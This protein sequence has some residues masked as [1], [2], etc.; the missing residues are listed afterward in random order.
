M[1]SMAPE[2]WVVLFQLQ[3]LRLE[4]LVARGGISRRGLALFTRLRTFDGH[5]FPGHSRLFLFFLFLF[6]LLLFTFSLG[7]TDSVDGTERAEASLT[8]SPFA[9]ELGLS[10]HREAS[11]G[12]SL[13][14]RLGDGLSS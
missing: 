3:L 9:F 14:P 10:L 1:K 6:G 5:N 12:N 13:K 4:F 7:D 2:G 11:P 8:E